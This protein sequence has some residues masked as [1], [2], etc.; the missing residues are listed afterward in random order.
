MPSQSTCCLSDTTGTS[1]QRTSYPGRARRGSRPLT[2]HDH[3]SSGLGKE[4]ILPE[5]LVCGQLEQ[6]VGH[7]DVGFD[8][9]DQRLCTT[10]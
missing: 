9:G 4:S 1:I 6:P 10:E 8:L 5:S 7:I 2:C 3:P